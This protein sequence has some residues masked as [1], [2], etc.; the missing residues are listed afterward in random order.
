LRQGSLFAPQLTAGFFILE[1]Y[2]L[3]RTEAATGIGSYFGAVI[4][5]NGEDPRA[6][7]AYKEVVDARRSVRIEVVS[8]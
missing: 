1:E 8:S 7:P 5:K 2:T 3:S 6:L 4:N